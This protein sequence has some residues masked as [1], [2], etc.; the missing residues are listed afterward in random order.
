MHV[1]GNVKR[2]VA[3]DGVEGS[4]GGPAAEAGVRNR[5]VHQSGQRSGQRSGLRWL[6]LFTFTLATIH[7]ARCYVMLTGYWIHLDTYAAGV[8]KM[9]FQGRML[10]MWPL[11][12]AERSGLLVRF[13]AHRLGALKSPELLVMTAT[14]I[15]SLGATGWIVNRMYRETSRRRLFPWLPYALLLAIAFVQFI[16]HSEQNFLYPYDLPSLLFFTAGAWLIYDKRLGEKRFW[17]LLLLFPV[18]TL[19]RETTMFLIPLLLLDACCE[20][21]R[22]R[23]RNALRPGVLAQAGVLSGIWVAIQMYVRHRFRNNPTDMG[24][25]FG[26]NVVYLTHPQYWPQLLSIGGFLPL[27]LLYFVKDIPDFRLRMYCWLF[28]V[29]LVA[30]SFFGMLVET[31]IF[32]ELSGLMALVGALIFEEVAWRRVEGLRVR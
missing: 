3:V 24:S 4:A 6:I 26:V 15:V 17:Y 29:W 19:N 12:W 2:D 18:A 16:L 22:L 31:R 32:G 27:F 23:W 11:R 28:P 30:M 1:N 25:H 5:A 9:P 14:A 8:E 13:T 21:G 7:F 20:E 10:M